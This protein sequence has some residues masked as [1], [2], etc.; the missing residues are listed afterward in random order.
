[1]DFLT[2]WWML[3]ILLGLFVF[4]GWLLLRRYA[5][6]KPTGGS[7][8]EQEEAEDDLLWLSKRNTYG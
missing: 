8:P 1:M 7:P 4:G 3:A 5:R 6:W 2:S